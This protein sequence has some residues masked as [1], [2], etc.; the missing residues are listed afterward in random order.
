MRARIF[1]EPFAAPAKLVEHYQRAALF[2]FPSLYEGFG[3][4]V[5]EARL[6]GTA[7]VVSDAVPALECLARD[8]GTCLLDFAAFDE[9]TSRGRRRLA[10]DAFLAC[11]KEP[12]R[13][14]EREWFGWERCA[15]EYAAVFK[16]LLKV[17]AA[18]DQTPAKKTA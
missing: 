18:L 17:N 14:L 12:V 1:E 16:G 4:P 11:P 15:A 9:G 5:V 13:L 8:P 3:L 7:A 10:L 2:V 6:C